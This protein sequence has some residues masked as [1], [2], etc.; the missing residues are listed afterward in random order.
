MVL[1]LMLMLMLMLGLILKFT[2]PAT[3]PGMAI[4]VASSLVLKGKDRR[5]PRRP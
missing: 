1:M 4:A 3:E 2:G 5:R